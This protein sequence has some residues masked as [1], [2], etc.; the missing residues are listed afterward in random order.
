M[1]YDHIKYDYDCIV[2]GAGPAGL[3]AACCAA[4]AGRRVLVLDKNNI[5]G[6]KLRITGKGRCNITNACEFDRLM[7]NIPDNGKFLFSSLKRFSNR[8]IIDFFENIGVRTVVERGGRVFPASQK[9]SDVA[10]AL[11][12]YTEGCGARILLSSKVT[13]ILTDEDTVYGVSY[14][15][16]SRDVHTVYAP[17]VIV[18][19]GGLSYP[20]TGST[21]DGYRFAQNAGHT[22]TPL[23]ASLAALIS[24]DEFIPDIEGLSLKNVSVV[25]YSEG[26]EVYRDFGE[27]LF[28]RNG[29]SGPVILSASAYY[30]PGA[31]TYISVDLKPALDVNMLYERIKRDFSGY[32]RKIFANSLDRLLPRKMIPVFVKRT[33]IDPH[34]Q[35]NQ[36]TREERMKIAAL[37]K[38]FTVGI[39]DIDDVRNA[40]VTAGGVCVKEIDPRTMESLKCRGLY[41]AGEVIDVDGYTGGFN[42]TIA[43]ST[44]HA[45]GTAAALK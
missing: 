33:C 45:A 28:T 11:A 4:E 30:R 17:S 34:K 36:I 29:I 13:E 23:R 31:H 27:C 43:F 24:K 25:L 20:G 22:V 6:R 18:A 2:I 8:D 10:E 42:L 44:G 3:M 1:K 41:F 35:V 19:T 26:R 21:G 15:G 37:L 5:A 38:D 40:V 16:G 39:D 12:A 14:T 7:E 9:A 32:D